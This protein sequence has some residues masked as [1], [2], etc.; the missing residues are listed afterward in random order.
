MYAAFDL[1]P[2][3]EYHHFRGGI[4][5]QSKYCANVTEGSLLLF[6]G[7]VDLTIVPS[8]RHKLGF[9]PVRGK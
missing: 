5:F 4:S 7:A 6:R 8:A 2:G 9:R 1:H 3:R